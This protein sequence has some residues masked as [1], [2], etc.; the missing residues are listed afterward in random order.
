MSSDFDPN[1]PTTLDTLLFMS[2]EGKEEFLIEVLKAYKVKNNLTDLQLFQEI[3]TNTDGVINRIEV[4]A[5]LERLKDSNNNDLF[6]KFET[7]TVGKR[8]HD[9]ICA[10]LL[11]NKDSNVTFDQFIETLKDSIAHDQVLFS[12]EFF[13][14]VEDW[15]IDVNWNLQNIPV[16]AYGGNE[17]GMGVVRGFNGGS[18]NTNGGNRSA[19]QPGSP[20]MPRIT[21]FI[22]NSGGAVNAGDPINYQF[23]D[24]TNLSAGSIAENIKSHTVSACPWGDRGIVSER[25]VIPGDYVNEFH[26]SVTPSASAG[27]TLYFPSVYGNIVSG[28]LVH[29][30][31]ISEG[32]TIIHDA[33]NGHFDSANGINILNGVGRT[34]F[35]FPNPGHHTVT[36]NLSGGNKR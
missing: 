14:E 29:S 26:G 17:V 4:Q 19:S 13:P 31:T 36:I 9:E 18:T 15:V 21:T 20:P 6:S 12:Y 25:V 11:K 22:A 10:K 28:D 32:G 1:T 30:R 2:T 8:V 34:M 23:F 27:I 35:V 5:F 3:N 24:I 16:S 33:K 7:D